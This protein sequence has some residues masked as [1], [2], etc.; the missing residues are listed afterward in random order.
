MIEGH[1]DSVGAADKNKELS[2]KR[3]K[4]VKDYLISKGV[5]ASRLTSA[6]FGE[7]NPIAQNR[8]RA[9]R[10]QNRRVEIKLVK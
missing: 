9:G 1:T 4:A 7:D 2:E 8:T 10:A 3:A 5:N 6:G